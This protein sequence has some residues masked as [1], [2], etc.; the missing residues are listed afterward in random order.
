MDASSGWQKAT[1]IT[2][3][4]H[5]VGRD[6]SD[7]I[8]ALEANGEYNYKL[9]SITPTLP[10]SVSI[11]PAASS[12]NFAGSVISSTVA[13]SAFGADGARIAAT[14]GLTISGSTMDF[15]AGVSTVN[16]TTSTSG[17]TNQAIRITGAGFSDILAAIAL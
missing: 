3:E 10:I 16:V 4:L 15:S 12:Y 5:C 14:V 7:R 6:S 13:V 11:T 2:N 17:D 9:H 1:T 8:F